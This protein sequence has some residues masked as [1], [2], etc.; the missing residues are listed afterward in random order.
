M[1]FEPIAIIG[2]SCVLPGALDPAELWEIVLHGRDMVTLAPDDAWRIEKQR[3]LA[4]PGATMQDRAWSDRGGYVRGFAE[5]FDPAGFLL[6]A[7]EIKALD[8][9]FQWTLHGVREAL[10]SAK[11]TAPL[12]ERA[13]PTGLILGNLS[14]P[15]A[16]LVQFAEATWFAAQSEA[17]P[18]PPDMS[19]PHARNR[20]SSGLPAH[21]AAQALNLRGDAFA[22]DAACASSLYAIKL[23]C[24]RLHDRRA[25]VMVAGAVNRT[26]DL[27]IHI[28]FCALQAMSRRGESRPFAADADG[29]VPGEGAAFVVL[30]RLDDAVAAGDE[31]LGVIRGVG[32]SN[33]GNAGG[34]LSPSAA[35]QVR[36]MEAAYAMAGLTPGD[37]SLLECHATGTPVGDAV[38]FA[39]LCELWRGERFTR[40]QCAIGSRPR[41]CGSSSASW[42]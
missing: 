34:F 9:V 5:R 40:G 21:L 26:D 25:D 30:K 19:T 42:R 29:L 8:P 16:G 33:D 7:D 3:I 31:I 41:R 14:Y 35:G 10:H 1:Q 22:L 27:F 6:P 24:D 4:G 12:P 36:A 23:A 28:G 13:P 20:F 2:H 32:L 39:S 17:I 37:I 18:R 38:E 15:T 11:L